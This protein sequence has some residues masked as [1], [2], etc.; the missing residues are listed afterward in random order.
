M[1]II[2]KQ[3]IQ[4]TI[5]IMIGFAIGAFNMILFAPKVLTAA[6]L[7]LTRI[8]IDAGVTLATMCTLGS[9]PVVYKFFPFYRN[10]LTSEKNDLPFVTIVICRGYLS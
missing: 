8:I 9:I 6:E 3:S 4:S 2:Q 1:G 10:Y 5:V 7:G